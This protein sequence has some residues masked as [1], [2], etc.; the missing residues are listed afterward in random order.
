MGNESTKKGER[1]EKMALYGWMT[2][3]VEELGWGGGEIG[4]RRRGE[5]RRMGKGERDLWA[6]V[7]LVLIR[8][9]LGEM[10]KIHTQ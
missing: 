1:E 9:W 7:S 2:S 8:T 4:Y 3:G 6:L 10:Q 5:R